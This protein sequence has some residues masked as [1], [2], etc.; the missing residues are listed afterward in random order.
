[1]SHL[2]INLVSHSKDPDIRQNSS[3]GCFCKSFLTYLVESKTVDFV[4]MMRMKEDSTEPEGII[5][6]DKNKIK[7]RSNSIYE[8]HDQTKILNSIE[9]DKKYAFIGLPCFVRYI[10]NQQIK[11]KKYLNIFPL[12]SI[13]CN[14]AP[15]PSAKQQLLKDNNINIDEVSE[16]DYRY[17]KFP[18]RVL[19]KFKDDRALLLDS[20]KS[21]WQK[22]NESFQYAPNCCLNCGLFESAFADIVVGDPWQTQYEKDTNGWTKV[23]VRNEES[24]NLID[25]SAINSYIS[26]IKLEKNE[27]FLA[28]KRSK[29]Y[30]HRIK[31]TGNKK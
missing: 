16:I 31:N 8:Y 9:N 4:I 14:Q 30:K 12:I 19:I 22:Y 5:T 6:N 24:M 7:T 2:E 20:S 25:N 27:S 15:N 26:I 13:L 18:G 3:S 11:N 21:F 29:E 10:R 23:I 1:M 28:Y 17:G